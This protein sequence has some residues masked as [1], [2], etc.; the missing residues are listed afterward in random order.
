LLIEHNKNDFENWKK[1]KAMELL[2]QMQMS[3]QHEGKSD[4]DLKVLV[5]EEMHAK[6][7][8]REAML[9]M[10]GVVPFSDEYLGIMDA[11]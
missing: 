11:D 10:P 1:R 2:K 5:E 4:E 9:E 6:I 7:R 3:E 8:E